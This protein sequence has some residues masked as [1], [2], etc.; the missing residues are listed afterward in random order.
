MV[1]MFY[2]QHDCNTDARGKFRMYIQI[3][4]DY[5]ST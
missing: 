4:L 5:T 3:L 1:E 2:D